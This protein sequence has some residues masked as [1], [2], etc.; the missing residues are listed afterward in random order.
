MTKIKNRTWGAWLERVMNGMSCSFSPRTPLNPYVLVA[1]WSIM[2]VLCKHKVEKIWGWKNCWESSTTTW[3]TNIR[4]LRPCFT[5]LILICFFILFFLLQLKKIHFWR[6]A[7]KAPA[8][9]L[10]NWI[11]FMEDTF[12]F[13]KNLVYKNIKV[14]NGPKIK[15][16]LRTCKG[17]KS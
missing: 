2:I 14:L 10:V 13:Y 1:I 6:L 9:N 12:F 15:N 3:V 4:L 7:T 8:L 17:F 5:L 11:A 16:I